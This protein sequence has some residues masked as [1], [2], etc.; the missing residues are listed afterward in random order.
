MTRLARKLG[1]FDYFTLSFG[2]MI[3]AGWLVV[4]D[5]WLARGGPVGTALGF[6]IGTLMLVPV[7][8]TYGRLVR[9]LPD[10]SS[11]VAYASRAFGHANL[12]FATGWMMTLAYIIVCP[13]E[14]LAIG[15]IA[16]YLLP[17]WFNRHP[18][19]SIAGTPVYAPN[20][21]LG[22][23]LTLFLTLLNYRGVRITAR[24]Q[25]VAT[26]LFA[27]LFVVFAAYGMLHGKTANL[28]PAF[29]HAPFVSV[30]LAMQIVPYF[31]TGF[32][33]VPKC[34]EE[35]K[36]GFGRERFGRAIF[37]ALF[38]G[39]AFYVVVVLLVGFIAPWQQLQG[40]R[41]ATA[42]AFQRVGA[43]SLLV[44][45]IFA[46]ALVSMVKVANGNFVAGSR[47][48]FGMAR[49]GLIA[50]PLAAV[51]SQRQ[52]PW[53]AVI[54]VGLFTA[55]TALL[56]DHLL[57]SVTEVGSLASAVGWL[58]ACAA[59]VRLAQTARDRAIAITGVVISLAF[60]S[61]KIL[62]GVPGSFSRGEYIALAAWIVTGLVLRMT[63]RVGSPASTAAIPEV[64]GTSE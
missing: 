64:V 10:A 19:Y 60:L 24:A 48:V 5:D 50:R 55:V 41:F 47:L 14:A 42:A 12:S 57:I 13:W 45:L 49:A 32:E 20:V 52:T 36:P 63:A 46:A 3:G 22:L 35:S 38:V 31:M 8:Y 21:A 18:L 53:F 56:G 33:A 25:N 2:T 29:S 6:A 58:I 1:G 17:Q 34:A 30:L 23:A 27:V 39:G 11:E 40:T 7:A 61:L 44:T 54:G 62:P 28:Q 26:V 43:G 4:M 15:R 9:L 51:H 37:A 59:F 16:A